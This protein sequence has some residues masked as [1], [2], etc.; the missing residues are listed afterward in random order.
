[1]RS[2]G[3]NTKI[4]DMTNLQNLLHNDPTEVW[5]SHIIQ[6]SETWMSYHDQFREPWQKYL[7]NILIIDLFYLYA[8]FGLDLVDR[9][10]VLSDTNRWA[11]LLSTRAHRHASLSTKLE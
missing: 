8:W 6:A 4:L 3:N 1:M 9:Y 2:D 10:S 7:K 5:D 11:C